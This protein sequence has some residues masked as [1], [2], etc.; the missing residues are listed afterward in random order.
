MREGDCAAE[1]PVV[2]IETGDGWSRY[3]SV[4]DADKL[5]QVREAISEEP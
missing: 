1:G 5:D 2:L 3:L 4:E